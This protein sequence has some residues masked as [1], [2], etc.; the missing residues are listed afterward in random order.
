ML[1]FLSLCLQPFTVKD[2]EVVLEAIEPRGARAAARILALDNHKV[3]GSEMEGVG[4]SEIEGVG[5]LR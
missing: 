2:L 5:V 4:G 1:L 3:G